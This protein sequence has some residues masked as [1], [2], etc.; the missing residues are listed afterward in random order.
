ML[1]RSLSGDTLHS[2]EHYSEYGT[3]SAAVYVVT[4]LWC[5]HS[6]RQT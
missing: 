4:E 1:Y 2:E 3:P 5:H 6:L